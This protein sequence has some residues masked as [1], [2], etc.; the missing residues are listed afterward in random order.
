MKKQLFDRLVESI[1]QHS[2]I[3]RGSRAPSRETHI[4][5]VVV[6]RGVR[7]KAP[8]RA[9]QRGPKNVMKALAR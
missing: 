8:L 1:E 5:R 2:E 6:N 9:I 3:I 7:A 4:D